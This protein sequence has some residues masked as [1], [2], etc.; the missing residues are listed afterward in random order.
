VHDPSRAGLARGRQQVG[1][2]EHVDGLQAL[3]VVCVV[4]DDAGEVEDGAGARA[5]REQG[6]GPRHVA[7]RALHAEPVERVAR[8]ALEHAHGAPLLAQAR[9][10]HA[11]EE[12]GGAGDEDG[13]HDGGAY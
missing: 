8:A 5:G 11:P 3:L 1:D 7:R 4:G 9:H 12:A 13:L 6:V 2:A 10:E